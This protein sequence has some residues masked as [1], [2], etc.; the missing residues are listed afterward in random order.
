MKSLFALILVACG[1]AAVP[2]DSTQ[3]TQSPQT[4]ATG[5]Y[6]GS[7]SVPVSAELAASA[8]YSVNEIEWTYTGGTATLSYKLPVELLGKSQRVSFS[9]PFGTTGTL[10][11]D[12][13]S[14]ECSTVDRTI[15]CRED[16]H[17]L[18]PIEHD[19]SRVSELAPANLASDRVSVT[20]VFISD[21]IGI[22]SFSF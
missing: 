9:G 17:A 13:G 18:M 8:S 1:G 15:T 11:G 10:V 3:G 4:P 7:Y 16:M 20:R 21:P 5:V 19:L 6:S 22:A 14:A 2:A 12:A